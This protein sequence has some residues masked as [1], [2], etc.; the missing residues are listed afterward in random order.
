VSAL[1]GWTEEDAAVHASLVAGIRQRPLLLAVNKVDQAP[2]FS[3]SLPP[4][5]RASF[6]STVGTSALR[7][8]GVA[9]LEESLARLLG[10][11]RLQSEGAAWAA[12]QRQAEALE[13]ACSALERLEEAVGSELPIDCWTIELRE[14]ALALGRVTGSDVGESVLD[15]IFSRFCIGK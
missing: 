11:G 10:V 4:H 13:Q 6:L 2:D 15:S 7:G 8:E 12:N 1:D 5:V 9:A 14:A 3:D